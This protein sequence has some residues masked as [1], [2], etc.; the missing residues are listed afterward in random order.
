M[1]ESCTLMS[2]VPGFVDSKRTGENGGRWDL[3][4]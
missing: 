3:I 1:Q 4:K 2:R